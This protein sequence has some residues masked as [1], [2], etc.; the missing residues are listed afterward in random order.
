MLVTTRGGDGR[1]NIMT[2]GFHMVMRHDPP[3]IGAV[4][5]PWDHSFA[6]LR[7]T[8]ECVFAIPTVD[9]AKTMVDIGNC[10]GSSVDKF[11]RFKLTAVDGETVK[12]PLI[13]E[14]IANIECRVADDVMVERYNLWVFEPVAIW[15]DRARKERRTL[16]HNGDGTFCIDGRVIDLKTRMT[17]WKG[18]QVEL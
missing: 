13:R 4:I 14:C 7:D 12:A 3:L 11:A 1:A 8:R 5:G 16:H 9:L 2:L 10:S 15:L 18:F 17:L 6:A